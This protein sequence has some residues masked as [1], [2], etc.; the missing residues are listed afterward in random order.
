MLHVMC[1]SFLFE[2]FYKMKNLQIDFNVKYI[3]IHFLPGLV[4]FGEDKMLKIFQIYLALKHQSI[5]I[6]F[7]SSWLVNGEKKSGWPIINKK[8]FTYNL[9]AVALQSLTGNGTFLCRH[10]MVKVDGSVKFS[11]NLSIKEMLVKSF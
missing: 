9:E 3:Q 5:T 8:R 10:F 11:F 1:F 4:Y 7:F 6:N 2:I